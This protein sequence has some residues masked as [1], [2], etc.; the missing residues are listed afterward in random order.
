M[1]RVIFY[2]V[3][4]LWGITTLSEADRFMGYEGFVYDAVDGS[5]ATIPYRLFVPADYDA[6]EQF[7]LLVYLHGV[8]QR[9]DDNK[10]QVRD[11]AEVPTL[12]TGDSLQST[13]PCFVL[14]PQCPSGRRWVDVPWGEGSYSLDDVDISA[15]LKSVVGIINGLRDT[16]SID[17][18]RIYMSGGS[19]GGFGAWDIVMR[20]PDLFAAAMPMCGGGDPSKASV[21]KH[22]AFWIWH[23]TND[24]VVPIEASREMF[25]GLEAAG[26]DVRLTEKEYG[27][28][29]WE[30]A[31]R[32]PGL[33]DWLF[34]ISKGEVVA[35]RPEQFAPAR[36]FSIRRNAG[37]QRNGYDARGRCTTRRWRSGIRIVIGKDGAACRFGPRLEPYLRERSRAHE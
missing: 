28:F 21:L 25:D 36:S 17:S 13:Y 16:F 12:F 19:M 1:I 6:S 14:V 11:F 22:I 29:I 4:L 24:G 37:S 20:Y 30:R 5:E 7:P 2:T 35:L 31:A 27:H 10:A 9:G 8:G 18:G 34:S 26:A 3:G 15:P 23:G 33:A 32:E